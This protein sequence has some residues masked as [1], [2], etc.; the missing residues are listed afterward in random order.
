M[1]RRAGCEIATLLS[2]LVLLAPAAGAQVTVVSGANF[3]PSLP[4]GLS[5]SLFGIG[6]APLTV[7]SGPG[8]GGNYPKQLG[9]LTSTIGGAAADLVMV[10]P[11]QIN[12]ELSAGL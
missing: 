4:P 10:S 7:A 11:S 2:L 3:Q 6:L 1:T 9:A 5:A 8:S 12:S